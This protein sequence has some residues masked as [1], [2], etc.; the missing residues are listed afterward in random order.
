MSG[1]RLGSKQI[2]DLRGNKASG[3]PA[4][5]QWAV[6]AG[7]CPEHPWSERGAGFVELEH[8]LAQSVPYGAAMPEGGTGVNLFV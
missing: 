7:G 3:A 4:G 5:L 1:T 2:S 6:V 8:C